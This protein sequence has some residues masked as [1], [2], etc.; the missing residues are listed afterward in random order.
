M[1]IRKRRTIHAAIG[2]FCLGLLVTASA[3][4]AQRDTQW[5]ALEIDP[6]WTNFRSF[7]TD[8]N[9]GVDNEA[10]SAFEQQYGDDFVTQ[11]DFRSRV[12]HLIYGPGIDTG[13]TNP[14]EAQAT[15]VAF[16]MIAE[17]NELFRLRDFDMDP[18][19]SHVKG[20][21]YVD[22]YLY[23]DAVPFDEHSRFA[24]RLKDNG[25]IAAIKTYDIPDT[26]EPSQATSDSGEAVRKVMASIVD[27]SHTSLNVSAP[28]LWY[29]VDGYGVAR[30]VWRFEVRNEDKTD[31]FGKEYFVHARDNM[32][33]FKINELIHY[34]HTGD[35]NATIQLQGPYDGATT[36]VALENARVTITA[37]GSGSTFTDQNGDF[38]FTGSG[39]RTIRSQL[40]G[41][42]SNVNNQAGGDISQSITASDGD[43][44]HFDHNSTSEFQLAQQDAYYWTN[45]VHDWSSAVMGNNGVEFELPTNVNISSSCNA[46]WDGS[47]INFYQSGGGCP[48]MAFSDVVAHEYGHGIDAGRGGI[49]DGGYSEGFGD[50]CA[51]HLTNQGCVGRGFF[52]PGT[53]LRDAKTI[54]LWPDPACGG[55]VHCR[56]HVYSGVAWTQAK[57]FK[58]VY[59]EQAGLTFSTAIVLAAGASNPAD[60]PDAV[61]EHFIADDDNGNLSDGTPN[62]TILADAAESRN[63]PYPLVTDASF[64]YPDG[65][66]EIL[67]QGGTTFR[68]NVA[69]L[70]SNPVADSGRL[71]YRFN[72][73]PW[74]TTSMT[75]IGMDQYEATIPSQNC[76]D[77]FDFYVEV[78]TDSGRVASDPIDAPDT[79]FTSIVA[80]EQ[81]TVL[82]DNFQTNMGW[83]VV[84]ESISTG[85]WQRAIPVDAGRDDPPADFDGSGFCYV[86]DN[87]ADADVDGGPTRLTSPT[88]DMTGG[89]IVSFA[90]WH[91]TDSDIFRAEISNNDGASYIPLM[92][93]NFGDGGW[94]TRAFRVEDFITPSSTM[95]VRFTVSDN[96]NDS[97]TESAVD[98][99][100]AVRL[101]CEEPP[102]LPRLFLLPNPTEA[103][104]SATV[105]VSDLQPAS[106]VKVYYARGV[107]DTGMGICPPELGGL[108]LDIVATAGSVKALTLTSSASGQAQRSR[109]VP[110]G[111]VGRTIVLQAANVLGAGGS[112][113]T[114]SNTIERVIQ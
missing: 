17:H 9:L 58:A 88:L 24:I 61:F 89:G 27:R 52:G 44:F 19:V 85:A 36:G 2:A 67:A 87:A 51:T 30:L 7:V 31:P 81:T 60:I 95:R 111:Y 110:P 20:T 25:V 74:V 41:L 71:V 21:W 54:Y 13:L 76:F 18:Y 28:E 64:S 34:D 69:P 12:P 40:N 45:L 97:V 39:S 29:L 11:W 63:V 55:G 92:A 65:L 72:E 106:T 105:F 6:E 50:A 42:W 75:S 109:N 23:H 66:P 48:N 90:F 103:G 114:L 70:A 26:I 35:V 5:A 79:F 43:N 83:T 96:P 94:E 112:E 56:G 59:G 32:Q 108:C 99:F 49:L 47:S 91:A 78:D 22:M 73:G 3:L 107:V 98:A 38:G 102:V 15:A 33:V 113:S 1:T 86:T 53:C 37:G 16:D 82:D 80:D 14:D 100:R 104:E 4:V 57:G 8:V 101:S 68:V 77:V 84:N 93:Q 10:W 46:F 62:Y